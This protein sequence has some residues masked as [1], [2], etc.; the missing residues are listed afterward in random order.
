M[1]D[2]FKAAL[3][4]K[5]WIDNLKTGLT[6]TRESFIARVK[7]IFRLSKID[8]ELWEELESILIGADAGVVTTE[9]IIREMRAVVR[10]RSLKDP[11]ELTEALKE[12]MALA[13]GEPKGLNTADGG[14]MVILVVGVNGTGKTTSIAKLAHRFKEDGKKVI[15]AAADTFRAAATEQL[16]I[17]AA[18]VNFE[19]VSHREGADPAAVVF[20]SI[21]AARAR[22]ADVLIVDTAGRLQTR[23]NLMEELKKVRRIIAREIPG[24]PHETLLVLDATTGQN[25]LQQARL[26]GAASD[27]SGIVLAKLDGTAK[28]GIVLAISSELGIP[29]KFIGL[30]EKIEDLREFDPRS[31][32]EALF[33]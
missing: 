1:F 20:D 30:G 6:R 23:V 8:D 2:R 32:L 16:E 10:E 11:E 25:A 9:R 18:R 13:L 12:R 27:V 31:F 14:L 17:W 15:V 28:G 26:F 7:N 29:V 33:S 5:Q 22:K 21:S 24:A 4:P 19:V 3:S